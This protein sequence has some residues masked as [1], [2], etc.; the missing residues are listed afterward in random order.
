MINTHVSE[1]TSEGVTICPL[2][3]PVKEENLYSEDSS[4]SSQTDPEADDLTWED[5]VDIWFS[6]MPEH[7]E[8]RGGRL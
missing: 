7:E 6:I 5:I 8:F 4:S 3:E 1:E 2:D